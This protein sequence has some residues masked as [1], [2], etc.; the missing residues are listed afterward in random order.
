[1]KKQLTSRVRVVF[2]VMFGMLLISTWLLDTADAA[3]GTIPVGINV[4]LS[5]AYKDQGKDEEM[6]YKLAT[7]MINQKGGVLGNKIRLIVKDTQTDAEV[8]RKNALDL[9]KKDK[10]VMISGGA[11]STVAIAQSDV[12]Q[13]NGVIF[14]AALTHSNATTGHM[15]TKSG[16]LAQKAHR[17]GFR[18]YFNAW[19]TG[20]ALGPYLVK[21][22]KPNAEY[23]Y[24]TADD[25]WGRS[26]EES[27]RW[28][29][30]AAGADTVGSVLTPLGQKNFIPELA[31][32]KKAKADVLVL[33]L[34]GRDLVIALKQA[35]DMGLKK[36][37]K[38]V[39]PLMEINMAHGV[40]PAVMEGVLASKNWYWGLKDRFPG[41]KE[42]VDA[43]RAK[44]QKAPGSAAAAAWVAIHEWAAAAAR[45]KSVASAKIIKALE[46]HEFAL[47]K[48][49]EQWRSWDHQV[50][51]SVYIVEGKAPSEVKD[52]WDLLKIISEV[53]GDVLVR[54]RAE[55]P[56]TLEPLQ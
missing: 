41:T 45:A 28:A 21:E 19:M 48:D 52:E 33:I 51:S 43:Y 50:I 42:F 24:V 36:K 38:I 34:F 5:G 14:M 55:N 44:Y 49:K 3:N 53:K 31:L 40:G 25:I 9:I 39:V 6:A 27:M 10:V 37:M 22:M 35:S 20:K 11:S 56:V 7:E 4:P 54:T 15:Q 47:L 13:E 12:C 29:T 17:H 18:W 8:A 46:G 32:A 2:V 1:M 16:Y 26:V 23:Y 30:E